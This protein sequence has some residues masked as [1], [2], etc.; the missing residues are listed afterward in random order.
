MRENSN[1]GSIVTILKKGELTTHKQITTWRH[2]AHTKDKSKQMWHILMYFIL[3]RHHQ[4]SCFELSI[5]ALLKCIKN[6]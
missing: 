1:L 2:L 5:L 3:M 4:K 6:I